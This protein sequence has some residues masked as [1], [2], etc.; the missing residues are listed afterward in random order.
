VRKFFYL[1][2]VWNIASQYRTFFSEP[3]FRY[4]IFW[5]LNFFLN[6]WPKI[7]KSTYFHTFFNPLRA[8]ACKNCSGKNCPKKNC[9]TKNFPRCQSVIL[10]PLSLS[11]SIDLHTNLVSLLFSICHFLNHVTEKMDIGWAHRN[12][13]ETI[14]LKFSTMFR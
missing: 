13:L 11:W 12:R 2:N 10:Y 9:W 6:F 3:G 4:R 7:K 1:Q 14:Y 5:A 8:T